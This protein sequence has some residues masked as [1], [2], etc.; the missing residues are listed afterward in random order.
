MLKDCNPC[1]GRQWEVEG[2]AKNKCDLKGG[3]TAGLPRVAIRM[4]G[5]FSRTADPL[6]LSLEEAAAEK[7]VDDLKKPSLYSSLVRVKTRV[8]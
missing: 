2:S 7:H 5:A 1:A 6:S 3:I 8:C 4:G